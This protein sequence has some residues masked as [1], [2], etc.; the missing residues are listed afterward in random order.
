MMNKQTEG[1]GVEDDFCFVSIFN[2]IVNHSD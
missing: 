2:N 1:S